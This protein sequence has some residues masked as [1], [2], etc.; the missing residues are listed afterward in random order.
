MTTHQK[1]L[2]FSSCIWTVAGVAWFIAL[3]GMP[4][5]GIMFMA[6]AL[7]LIGGRETAVEIEVRGLDRC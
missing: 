4:W 3:M 6:I 2:I 1:Y 7:V 5:L